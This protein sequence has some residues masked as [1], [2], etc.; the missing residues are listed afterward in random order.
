MSKQDIVRGTDMNA[1]PYQPPEQ[2]WEAT[3]DTFELPGRPRR[4]FWGPWSALVLA[5]LV[6]VVGFYVGIRVEKGQLSSATSTLGAG[7]GAASRTG[8]AA[9]GSRAGAGSTA[10][11]GGRTGGFGGG[12]GR[13]LGGGAG[14]ANASFGTVSSING[15]TIYLT[16]VTGN[17]VKVRLTSATKVTKSVSVAKKSVRP[18]DT[19]VVSGLKGSHGTITAATVAD[20]GA[21]SGAFGGGARGGGG[22]GSG[23][24]ASSSASSAVNSLF[25]SGGGG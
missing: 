5:V 24:G 1:I 23:S 20:S 2:E 11:A 18:G 6:G 19:V 22:S 7:L 17:T 9:A 16:D 14:G 8:A 4:R 21:R 15:N 3:E 10:S 25:G 13:A 12:F